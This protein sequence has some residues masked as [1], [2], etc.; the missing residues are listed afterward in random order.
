MHPL[1]YDEFEKVKD[2]E[3]SRCG[4]PLKRHWKSGD[5]T[6]PMLLRLGGC[7]KCKDACPLFVRNWWNR[8]FESMER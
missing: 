8:T 2:V 7:G 6:R 5:G 3:C 1:R 4:C